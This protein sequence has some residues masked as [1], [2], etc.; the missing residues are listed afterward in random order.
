MLGRQRRRWQLGLCQAVAAHWKMSFR[1]RFGFAGFFSLPFYIFV[2]S[3]GA[4]VEFIGY[5]V[6]PLAFA[7]HLALLSFYIPLV[8]LSLIYAAFLSIGAVLI[9]EMTDRPYPA[10][11]DLYTLIKWSVFENFGFR[12]LILYF[13]FQG[14]LRFF[15]GARQWETVSHAADEATYGDS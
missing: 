2:E 5:I 6:V 10:A 4:A 8:I 9:E 1:P 3:A 15:A 14:L 7:F 13:R 11:R 12:Q